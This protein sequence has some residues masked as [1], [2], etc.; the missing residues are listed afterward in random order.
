MDETRAHVNWRTPTTPGC[1]VHS[2]RLL[3][4]TVHTA[5]FE[6]SARGAGLGGA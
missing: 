3:D 1:Y 6:L 5:A 4:G 2:V